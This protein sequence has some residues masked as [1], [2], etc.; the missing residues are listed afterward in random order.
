VTLEIETNLNLGRIYTALGDYRAAVDCL[1]WNVAVLEGDRLRQQFGER[2]GEQGV[3]NLQSR[4]W[5][6][7]CLAECG[8]FGDA[9]ELA[10]DV[11]RI[12]ER[13]TRPFIRVAAARDLGHVYLWRGDVDKAISVLEHGLSICR[14]APVPGLLPIVASL[15]GSA[16]ALA[17]RVAEALPLL[18]LAVA[19]ASSMGLMYG[20]SL[21]VSLLGEG[22]LL[23]GR[24]EEAHAR[25]EES[26]SFAQTHRERAYEATALRLLGEI[27]ARRDPPLSESAEG[28]YHR[29]LALALE[30]GMRPLVA[31]CHLGLGKLYRRTDKGEQAQQHLATATAMY[32]EMGMTYWLEKAERETTDIGR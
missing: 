6:G 26:L 9:L 16:Y 3:P 1:R 15:L 13:T 5:L 32:R 18:E 21:W 17:G 25:A 29:A 31:H 23:A 8:T 7:R 11:M 20:H 24:L 19:Q 2:Y 30:L 10:E 12:A 28:H 14:T 22:Y 4:S 27:H